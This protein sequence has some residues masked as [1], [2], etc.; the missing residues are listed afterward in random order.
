MIE[1]LPTEEAKNSKKKKKIK[2]KKNWFKNEKKKDKKGKIR[3]VFKWINRKK[4]EK[5]KIF[6]E[7]KIKIKWCSF[8]FS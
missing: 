5:K 8:Q 7:I 3:I 1:T 6:F 4:N 2:L